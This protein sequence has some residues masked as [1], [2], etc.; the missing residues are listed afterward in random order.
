M[1]YRFILNE[2]S[3][4]G[5]GAVK[6]IIPEITSRGFKKALIVTDEDLVKFGVVK[7]VTDLLDGAGM[8]YDIYDKVKANPSVD[9][10]KNGV[11][12]FKSAGADYLIAIGGGSPQDTAK[13]IGIIIN[14]PEFADVVSLEGVAPTKNKAVPMIAIATTAGTAAE[15]TINY[16]ITDEE[17]RRKFVCVDPHDIPVVA[18]V[19]PEMMATMPKGLTA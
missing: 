15:T 3:Y 10:V 7:R 13:G 11:E 16:V 6:E 14:N 8:A 12:A 2:T 17:K 1:S 5:A 9:V 4:H 19:D 18:V